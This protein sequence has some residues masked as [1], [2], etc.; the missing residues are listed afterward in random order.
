MDKVLA[1]SEFDF[2]FPKYD[3]LPK[4]RVVILRLQGFGVVSIIGLNLNLT[5]VSDLAL[6]IIHSGMY[7][8]V[9]VWLKIRH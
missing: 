4:E 3:L 6:F 7:M 9:Q 1:M 8:R 2:P 5:I